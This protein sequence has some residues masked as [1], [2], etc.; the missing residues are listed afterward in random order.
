MIPLIGEILAAYFYIYAFIEA[1]HKWKIILGICLLC[2]FIVSM[3]SFI[4]Y[5]YLF[6]LL[7]R[8]SIGIICFMWLKAKGKIKMR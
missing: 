1:S 6:S 7:G 3:F 5:M 8:I 2:T 4:P